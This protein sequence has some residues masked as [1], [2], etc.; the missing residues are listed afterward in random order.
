MHVI[1]VESIDCVE[2]GLRM[3]DEHLNP[4]V[5]NMANAFH[6]G[7]GY[8]HGAGAQ[9]ENLCRRSAYCLALEAPEALYGLIRQRREDHYPLDVEDGLYTPDV[10]ILRGSEDAGY[11]WLTHPRRLSFVAVA[12]IDKPRVTK[13]RIPRLASPDREITA[14]KIRTILRIAHCHRHDALVLSALGCGAFANPPAD[15]ALVFHEV[16]SE[17]EFNG[18]FK[19]IVFAILDDQNAG[20]A[21]NP[22]GNFRPFRRQ[23]PS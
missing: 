15:V 23:F 6:P 3:Q 18:A 12:A 16:L 5:L 7:G 2:A 9:E 20:K 14:R 10:L 19:Q 13:D 8:L 21:H 1:R 17:P 4:V 22:D 11:E